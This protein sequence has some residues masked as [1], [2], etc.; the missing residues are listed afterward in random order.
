MVPGVAPGQTARKLRCGNARLP[1]HPGEEG[2]APRLAARGGGQLGWPAE[3]SRAG[4]AAASWRAPRVRLKSASPAAIRIQSPGLGQRCRVESV[5]SI[6]FS[7]QNIFGIPANTNIRFQENY[8]F[9]EF[10]LR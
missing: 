9:G 6:S 5:S 3:A 4:R 8:I 2:L 7:K 10:F 1:A